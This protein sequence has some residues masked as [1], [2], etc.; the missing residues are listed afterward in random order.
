MI[1]L[2]EALEDMLADRPR[3][4]ATASRREY[5]REANVTEDAALPSVVAD[6]LY[7]DFASEA[8]QEN[9]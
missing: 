4:E 5:P 2:I 1:D 3:D 6:C 9:S 8:I 7:D